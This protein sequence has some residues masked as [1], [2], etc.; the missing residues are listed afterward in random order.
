MNKVLKGLVAVAAT[1]AMAIA[2]VAGAATAMAARGVYHNRR[3]RSLTIKNSAAG[4]T[5]DAYQ[6]FKGRIS[7]SAAC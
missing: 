3:I 7:D 5:Y 2:G 1:A 6:V 4:H